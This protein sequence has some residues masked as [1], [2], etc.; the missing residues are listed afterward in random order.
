MNLANRVGVSLVLLIVIAVALLLALVPG[1]LE[2]PFQ[3]GLAVAQHRLDTLS[4][5]MIALGGLLVAVI[6]LLL[7]AA[8]WRRPSKRAVVVAR[9]PG[10]TAELAVD[11][12]AMRLRQAAEGV[13]GV[14][15]ASPMVKARRG[16]I[17]V[18]MTLS[19]DSDLDLPDKSKEVMD[20]VRAE[21]EGRMGIA[22]KSL[23]VTF[24]HSSQG[25]RR[26]SPPVNRP[27]GPAET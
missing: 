5:L 9:T 12:V 11:S 10:G 18:L 2:A 15:E 14:R 21:A 3:V 4:Q 17:D 16:G 8:E 27:S 25:S 22:V 7:L 26:P 20:A 19:A 1:Y 24:K 13:A 23:R 6:A